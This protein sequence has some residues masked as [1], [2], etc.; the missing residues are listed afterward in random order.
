RVGLGGTEGLDFGTRTRQMLNLFGTGYGIGVQDRS[1]YY[2]SD[3]QF[4]WYQG[5]VHSDV[6]GDA[7]GG[8]R[9]MYL[10]PTAGLVLERGIYSGSDRNIKTNIVVTDAR[11]VL[12]K[13]LAL[14]VASWSY[15]NETS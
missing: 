10:H 12:A 1:L 2:R 11:Q 14:P 13:V 4:V 8:T 5:G 9:L 15:T 6:I 3:L 7:G